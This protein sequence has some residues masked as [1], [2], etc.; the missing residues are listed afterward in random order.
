M[1]KISRIHIAKTPY[2]IGVGAEKELHKYLSEIRHELD[3]ELA[4]DIMADVEV[5]VTEILSD[6]ST[7]R[8]EVITAKDI[9]AVKEQLGS[10]E[11]FNDRETSSEQE[12]TNTKEPKKLFRDPDGAFL[13]GV[14]S[15]LGAHFGIDPIFVRLIFIALIFASGLGILLYL[16]LWV[17]VP[18]AKTNS[19]KLQM[20]GEPVTAATLQRYRGEA[21]ASPTAAR[22]RAVLRVVFLLCRVLCTAI[23]ALLIVAL[24]SGVGF[25]S[26]ILNTQPLHQ[27]F[28]LY[29]LNFVLFGLLWL[30]TLTLIGLALVVLMRLWRQRPPKLRVAVAALLGLLVLTTAGVAVVTHF[31]ANYYRNLYGDNKLTV[32]IPVRADSTAPLPNQLELSGDNNLVVSYV[33]TSG[34]IHATYQGYPGMGRPDVT[35]SNTNGTIDVAAGDL[36]NVAPDCLLGWCRHV[37]LPVKMTVYG[38]ALPKFTVRGG[39]EV[40]LANLDQTSITAESQSGSNIM[41]DNSYAGDITLDAESGSSIDASD[42]T[43]QTTTIMVS[44]DSTI[45]GPATNTLSATLPGDCDQN[46]LELAQSPAVVELN[47]KAISAQSFM[48]NSCVTIDNPSQFNGV[49]LRGRLIAPVMPNPPTLGR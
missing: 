46:L 34:P 43:G 22:L 48:Q 23:L 3:P 19:D 11:Q 18:E 24:L 5:R 39:A 44:D 49:S 20:R 1:D 29:R 36:S 38:P 10:P 8:N 9:E 21:Q 25:A 41:L 35:V 47:G 6:L 30:F 2:E 37:Y 26:A 27:I 32:A 12:P 4:D 45:L 28:L 33:V 15:G 40:D 17:L 7:K 13:G 42:S 14:A 16:L 31:V